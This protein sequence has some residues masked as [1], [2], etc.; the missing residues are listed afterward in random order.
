MDNRKFL[1][2]NWTSLCVSLL[3]LLRRDEAFKGHSF[4]K[5]PTNVLRKCDFGVFACPCS[6]RSCALRTSFNV[7]M[8]LVTRD[9]QGSPELTVRRIESVDCDFASVINV[10][11]EKKLQGR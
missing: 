1:A 2:S 4:E 7:R 11:A 6:Y 10:V 3:R 9:R 5:L 8:R